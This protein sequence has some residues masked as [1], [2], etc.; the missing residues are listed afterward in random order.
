[1]TDAAELK[2]KLVREEAEYRALQDYYE[3]LFAMYGT[4][5]WK[6]LME[7][8]LHMHQA[9]DRASGLKTNEELWF[10]HGELSMMQWLLNHQ[11]AVEASFAAMVA[12]REGTEEEAP[13]GGTAKLVK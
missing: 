11:H 3:S 12:E 2:E 13:T 7:D 10:R 5:G 1:M 6:A 9:N 4:R 8:V